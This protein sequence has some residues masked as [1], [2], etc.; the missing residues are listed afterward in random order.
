MKTRQDERHA[1]G[2]GRRRAGAPAS[3]HRGEPAGPKK[4][5][6]DVTKLGTVTV[7]PNPNPGPDAHD[8]LR[9]IFTIL[10]R[11]VYEDGEASTGD[12]RTRDEPGEAERDP[13]SDNR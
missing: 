8:R 1:S 2:R 4:C 10:A 11:I 12:P 5:G 7:V 13:R 9:R 6:R 3:F